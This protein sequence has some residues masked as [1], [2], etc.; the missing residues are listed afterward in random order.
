MWNAPAGRRAS[1]THVGLHPRLCCT[2]CCA[3]TRRTGALVARE[4]RSKRRCR[5]ADGTAQLGTLQ[6]GANSR[7]RQTAAFGWRA[8]S[9]AGCPHCPGA[10]RPVPSG[11]QHITRTVSATGQRQARQEQHQAGTDGHSENWGSWIAAATRRAQLRA[12]GSRKEAVSA[13]RVQALGEWRRT[14]PH[15]CHP[16][17]AWQ[18]A[19]KPLPCSPSSPS[20][21]PS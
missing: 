7:R 2:R 12:A 11:R 5:R 6:L 21:A 4:A 14:R 16:L 9:A 15:F 17:S 10:C 19:H 1:S 13:C 3:P 8:R 18:S 20:R